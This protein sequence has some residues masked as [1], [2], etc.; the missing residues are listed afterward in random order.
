M[1]ESHLRSLIKAISWRVF[2]TIAT[3]LIAYFFTHKLN[4][5]LYI[6][7]FEFSSKIGLFYLHERLW[8]ATSLGLFSTHPKEQ[9]Q[10]DLRYIINKDPSYE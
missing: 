9:P 1:K 8:N 7:L 4:L 10:G 2:G 6:G 3:M 5:T